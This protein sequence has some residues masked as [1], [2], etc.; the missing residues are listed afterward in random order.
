MFD[1]QSLCSNQSQPDWISTVGIHSYYHSITSFVNCKKIK[2]FT[3]QRTYHTNTHK[4]TNTKK[5]NSYQL[6]QTAKSIEYLW[7]KR[8]FITYPQSNVNIDSTQPLYCDL[9]VNTY[10]NSSTTENIIRFN[11]LLPPL[12]TSGEISNLSPY[13][14]STFIPKNTLFNIQNIQIHIQFTDRSYDTIQNTLKKSRDH[15]K[16]LSI[17]RK[18]RRFHELSNNK[19]IRQSKRIRNKL[20]REIFDF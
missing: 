10:I 15:D 4:T 3:F 16:Y 12:H 9:N 2:T 5:G 13:N 20:H 14:L 7:S 6:E 8:N 11:D 18:K 19:N 1:L 17:K